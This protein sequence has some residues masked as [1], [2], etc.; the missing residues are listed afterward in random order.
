LFDMIKE[1]KD[2]FNQQVMISTT[3]K[4][5]ETIKWHTL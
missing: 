4:E 1:D 2:D 5:R 3:I